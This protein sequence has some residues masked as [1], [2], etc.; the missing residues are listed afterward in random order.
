MSRVWPSTV[1]LTRNLALAHTFQGSFKKFPLPVLSLILWR[2]L[3]LLC[4]GHLHHLLAV[5]SYFPCLAATMLPCSLCLVFL[6][7][8]CWWAVVF[9]VLGCVVRTHCGVLWYDIWYLV[10]G[11]T[12]SATTPPPLLQP[13]FSRRHATRSVRLPLR[14][15]E[16]PGT[17]PLS[18]FMRRSVLQGVLVQWRKYRVAIKKS[19]SANQKLR[20]SCLVLLVLYRKRSFLMIVIVLYL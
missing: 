7:C 15:E 9:C 17:G 8:C 6:R 12:T 16:P 14:S 13:P 4:R 2:L 5:L 18:Y 20:L 3:Y 10:P 19:R 11:T 1:S